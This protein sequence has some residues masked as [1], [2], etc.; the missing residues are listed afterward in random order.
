MGA[1]S[2]DLAGVSDVVIC[3]RYAHWR[4]GTSVG[5]RASLVVRSSRMLEPTLDGEQ[6]AFD[7]LRA[8][9]DGT[10]THAWYDMHGSV[11]Y[12]FLVGHSRAAETI[13]ASESA[14]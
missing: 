14:V 9:S 3:T 12:G 11:F 5:P 8:G 10:H 6:F 13:A 7:V 4:N 1:S 2:P